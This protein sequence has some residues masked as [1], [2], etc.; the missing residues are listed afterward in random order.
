[1]FDAGMHH[2]RRTVV[3]G[4]L[5]QAVCGRDPKQKLEM[6]TLSYFGPML[7]TATGTITSAIL[8]EALKIT[9]WT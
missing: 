1:M 7:C 4:A 2:S 3:S 6:T 9:H 5:Q 8:L